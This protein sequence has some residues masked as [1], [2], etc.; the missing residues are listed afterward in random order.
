MKRFSATELSHVKELVKKGASLN[1]ISAQTGRCK[2]AVQYQVAKTRGK[3]PREKTLKTEE[4][5]DL[6]LGWL[7]GCYAGDGSR[8]FRKEDYAYDIK[9]ALNENEF[10]IVERVENFLSKCELRTWRSIE[11]KRVYVRCRNKK[12]FYFVEKFLAWE[13][14]RKSKSVRLASP[15]CCS[16]D[17]LFGFLCGVID[18]EGGTKKLYISTSSGRLAENIMEIAGKMGIQSRKY[19]YDVFHVYLRKA[20]FQKACQNHGFSSIKHSRKL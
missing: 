15:E 7:I 4:L 17:F 20:A 12:F 6:E 8:H 2:S 11:G 18:A 3:N 10:P 5:T 9:F 16:N 19:S 14:T 13:G 1:E